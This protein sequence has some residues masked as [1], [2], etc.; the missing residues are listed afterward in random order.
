MAVPGWENPKYYIQAGTE[1]W[2]APSWVRKLTNTFFV[3]IYDPDQ[4]PLLHFRRAIQTDSLMD[5]SSRLKGK[6]LTVQTVEQ[7]PQRR[8]WI[9]HFQQNPEGKFFL[10]SEETAINPPRLDSGVRTFFGR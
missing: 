2:C 9:F 6:T 1:V 10:K 3:S 7:T 4:E 8:A 5:Q